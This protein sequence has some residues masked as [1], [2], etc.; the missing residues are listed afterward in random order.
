MLS[1]PAA[2]ATLISTVSALLLALAAHALLPALGGWLDAA[3]FVAGVAVPI[4][5]TA[6]ACSLAWALSVGGRGVAFREAMRHISRGDLSAGVPDVPFTGA[7]DLLGIRRAFKAMRDDLDQALKRLAH[8]DAQRRRLFADLAHELATP[9]SALL[10][11]ADT[12]GAPELAIDEVTTRRL[13]AGLE[14]E[15]LR[16]SRLVQDIRDLAELDDPDVSFVKEEV[17]VGAVVTAAVDRFSSMEGARIEVNCEPALAAIDALRIDQAVA[18]LVRNARRYTPP[19]RRI[20]VSTRRVGP[21]VAVVVEDEGAGVPR[22]ALP[23][24]GERLF[25]VGD[26][27]D[28]GTGGHG[29]GLSIVRAILARHG[30][31]VVF[32][33]GDAGGLRVTLGLPAA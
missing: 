14:A 4:A 12:M 24:L 1:R 3:T 22:E 28:R 33:H 23:R 19:E 5:L 15:A 16:L 31:T 18:N 11:I 10:A 25:R 29:L 13:V 27:R 17:D 26:A 6:I 7:E 2:R 32:A 8:A 30:G 20:L 9:A 21:C